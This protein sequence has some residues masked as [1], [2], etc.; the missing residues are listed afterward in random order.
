MYALVEVR[1]FGD[2][3]VCIPPLDLDLSW[4]HIDVAWND[5]SLGDGLLMSNDVAWSPGYRGLPL[6]PHGRRLEPVLLSLRWSGGPTL[7]QRFRLG[8]FPPG[9]YALVARYHPW[10]DLDGKRT[11]GSDAWSAPVA[12]RVTQRDSEESRDF[13]AWGTLVAR[14]PDQWPAAV[15]DSLMAVLGGR[16]AR[17]SADPVAIALAEPLVAV[18][19]VAEGSSRYDA[20]ANA[21]F[22]AAARAAP[23]SP[24]GAWAAREYAGWMWARDRN[25]VTRLAASLEGTVAGDLL[26]QA[27]TLSDRAVPSRCSPRR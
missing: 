26:R 4:L 14:P 18:A 8:V 24:I 20:T 12:F 7:S 21:W 5:S 16:V 6:A 3:T 2:D 9:Q 27:P 11:A 15:T 1:N 17:D 22:S 23:N 19:H 10:M 13:A 25:T